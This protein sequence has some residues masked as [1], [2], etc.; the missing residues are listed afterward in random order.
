MV[1]H[2]PDDLF[3]ITGKMRYSAGTAR[4]SDGRFN[5]HQNP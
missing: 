4:E 2:F 5:K 1:T 3:E